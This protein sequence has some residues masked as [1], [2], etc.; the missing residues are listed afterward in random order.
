MQRRRAIEVHPSA[1]VAKTD[2]VGRFVGIEDK[3]SSC[4]SSESDGVGRSAVVRIVMG[5]RVHIGVELNR[6]ESEGGC[7]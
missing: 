7:V 5:F 1:L 3:S 2:S 4:E 6:V